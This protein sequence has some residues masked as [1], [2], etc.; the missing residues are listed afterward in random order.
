MDTLRLAASVAMQ[1][2]VSIIRGS[3]YTFIKSV[4]VASSLEHDKEELSL[5]LG[6]LDRWATYV[7]IELVNHLHAFWSKGELQSARAG[8]HAREV[9]LSVADLG[10]LC[11]ITY[12][13]V[14]SLSVCICCVRCILS[15]ELTKIFQYSWRFM[16]RH[17]RV[18][19]HRLFRSQ[20]SL[21]HRQVIVN[22]CSLVLRHHR[23]IGLMN[24]AVGK[25]DHGW[26]YG[27]AGRRKGWRGMKV[28]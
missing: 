26:L 21:V 4:R 20:R 28:V 24:G 19:D 9:W 2:Y 17:R 12:R 6:I 8:T 18:I 14:L 13:S 7:W 15:S 25:H 3:K 5:P 11:M 1:G 27:R 23:T 16:M 22:L 10:S